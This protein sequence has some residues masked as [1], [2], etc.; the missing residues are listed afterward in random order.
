MKKG[1]LVCMGL[2]V[3]SVQSAHGADRTLPKGSLL[4][5]SAASIERLE[6]GDY[7]LIRGCRLSRQD[8]AV[9][10]LQTSTAGSA[11]VYVPARNVRAYVQ[12]N[13]LK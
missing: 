8:M 5:D 10:I 9:E 12:R 7:Q 4:C 3:A 13:A 1:T 11:Q 6:Q 2:F